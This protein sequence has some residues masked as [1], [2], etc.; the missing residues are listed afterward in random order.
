MRMPGQANPEFLLLQ[1]MVPPGRQ[2]MIAWVAA[3]N[4]PADYGR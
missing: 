3:H 2:N 4:D 1:P